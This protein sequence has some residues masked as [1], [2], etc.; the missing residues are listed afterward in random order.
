[1]ASDPYFKNFQYLKSEIGQR[2]RVGVISRYYEGANVISK[3][4]LI[5]EYDGF[6]GGQPIGSR[7]FGAE[8]FGGKNDFHGRLVQATFTPLNSKDVFPVLIRSNGSLAFTENSPCGQGLL[9]QVNGIADGYRRYY[10]S[11]YGPE[12][13]AR[14]TL[15]F[16]MT[17]ETTN[18][19]NYL[20]DTGLVS[21]KRILSPASSQ[22]S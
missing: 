20:I 16:G 14:T 9:R 3:A 6:Q 21:V 1:M 13:S 18:F 10:N 11:N 12:I 17:T 19:R 15:D 4:D 22:V 2:Y 5:Y 7:W 8:A